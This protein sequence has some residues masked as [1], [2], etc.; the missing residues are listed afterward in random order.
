MADYRIDC[1]HK[2]DRMSA[3][4]HI[5]QAGGPKSEGGRWQDSVENIVR[6]IEN[7]Q[8]RFYTKEGNSSAWVGVRSSASGRKFIQ[9]YADGVWKDNLLALNECSI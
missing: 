6:F 3:H 8:H 9:T 5:T 4:E 1:V 2:P 7:K